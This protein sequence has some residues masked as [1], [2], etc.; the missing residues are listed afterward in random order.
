MSLQERRQQ[1][2]EKIQRME[3]Q[4][5]KEQEDASFRSAARAAERRQKN[6]DRVCLTHSLS[7]PD[8][9]AVLAHV[10]PE[11]G[12]TNKNTLLAL[13]VLNRLAKTYAIRPEDVITVMKEIV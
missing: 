8:A 12:F 5:Q 6:L 4:R 10:C 3:E 1:K 11:L 13:Q 7:T 9:E 2:I